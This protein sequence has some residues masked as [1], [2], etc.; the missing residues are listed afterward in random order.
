M[1]EK[2]LLAVSEQFFKL[3]MQ[4]HKN[5]LKP[6]EFMKGMPIP[7][8]HVKVIFYLSH[9]GAV[10]VSTIA[11]DLLISKPNMT[12]IIDKLFEEGYVSR[13]EDP[14]DRRILRIEITEKSKEIFKLKKELAVKSLISKLSNLNSEDISTLSSNLDSV[15]KI[16]EKLN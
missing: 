4:L 5:V 11:K 12:P 9:K 6:E 16:L 3:I 13:S 15:Y 8:S 10:P 2:N 1:D 14:N 7:P